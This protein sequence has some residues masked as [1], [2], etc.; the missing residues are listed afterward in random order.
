MA[1][2]IQALT[3]RLWPAMIQIVREHNRFLHASIEKEMVK[4]LR[5]AVDQ[6]I[7]GEADLQL[8]IASCY[9]IHPEA[10]DLR[11][12]LLAARRIQLAKVL[13]DSRCRRM[14][15]RVFEGDQ[16]RWTPR[17]ANHARSTLERA[18][19]GSDLPSE[20][21]AA[22]TGAPAVESDRHCWPSRRTC[23]TTTGSRHSA[24]NGRSPFRA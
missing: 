24:P 12:S 2:F 19:P 16:A 11:K 18:K 14:G 6:K 4:A 13:R 10:L 15:G 22:S 1:H 9:L 20:P 21:A 17:C 7:S 23:E 8:A 5:Q 3:R